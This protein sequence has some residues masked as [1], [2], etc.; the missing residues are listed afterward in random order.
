MWN[1]ANKKNNKRPYAILILAVWGCM[2]PICPYKTPMGHTQTTQSN[3][4]RPYVLVRAR[5]IFS[6]LS[7]HG[8]VAMAMC[9]FMR[10]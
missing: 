3:N 6:L 8:H 7:R 1:V 4:N 9:W 2:V 5:I 10:G